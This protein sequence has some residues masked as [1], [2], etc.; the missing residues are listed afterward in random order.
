MAHHV[1]LSSLLP[2]QKSSVEITTC[3][4]R[5]CKG[6][7]RSEHWL[8]A[9][10]CRRVQ[11]C[12]GLCGLGSLLLRALTSRAPTG[13]AL[14]SGLSIGWLHL[15]TAAPCPEGGSATQTLSSALRS[16]CPGLRSGAEL[17]GR[18]ETSSP[19]LSGAVPDAPSPHVVSHWPLVLVDSAFFQ[20]LPALEDC[21]QPFP[22]NTADVHREGFSGAGDLERSG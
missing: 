5:R 15:P 17:T 8:G 7:S 9:S 16:A 11:R 19:R 21:R 13:M 10:E 14:T 2:S 20:V 3:V 12:L 1:L 4:I 18:K 22:V 6:C